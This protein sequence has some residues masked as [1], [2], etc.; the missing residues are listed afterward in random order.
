MMT[1]ASWHLWARVIATWGLA[2]AAGCSDGSGGQGGAYDYKPT[3][4]IAPLPHQAASPGPPRLL[5]PRVTVGVLGLEDDA[6]L[7]CVA[8]PEEYERGHI[9]GSALIPVQALAAALAGN[10][11]VPE[12][13]H[14]RLP[15]QDQRIILYCWWKSCEC[16]SQPTYSELA[17]RLLLRK[18]YRNVSIIDGG[19][20]AWLQAGLP[21]E[22]S[23]PATR[24]SLRLPKQ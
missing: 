22:K 24:P 11:P 23:P 4:E 3:P 20:R 1:T 10:D 8:T 13:N 12:I 17:R 18:G 6:F 2:L 19:M 15:R 7:L 14:G 5:S 9:I 21:A 16:P